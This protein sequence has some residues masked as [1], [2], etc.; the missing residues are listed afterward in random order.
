M[1]AYSKSDEPGDRWDNGEDEPRHVDRDE[2]D[3]GDDLE[4][5]SQRLNDAVRDRVVDLVDTNDPPLTKNSIGK[6]HDILI[7]REPI[8]DATYRSRIV[9]L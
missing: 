7:L 4:E 6:A 2:H 1:K 3:S 5:R 8:Q 9:E